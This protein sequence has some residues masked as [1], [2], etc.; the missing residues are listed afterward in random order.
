MDSTVNSPL[1]ELLERVDGALVAAAQLVAGALSDEGG[2]VSERS[3]RGPPLA[4]CVLKEVGEREA[5]R[6][7]GVLLAES[8]GAVREV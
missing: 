5:R 2:T 3:I 6:D 8:R 1:H 4:S 7:H